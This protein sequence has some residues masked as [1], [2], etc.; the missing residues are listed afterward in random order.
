MSV[1]LENVFTLSKLE[2]MFLTWQNVLRKLGKIQGSPRLL[3]TGVIN[4][5]FLLIIRR[6][7]EVFS[8]LLC[9]EFFR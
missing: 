2:K 3:Q 1:A 4:P 8:L 9:L 6:V 7:L 5:F